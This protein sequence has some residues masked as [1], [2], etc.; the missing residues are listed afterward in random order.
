MENVHG[1]QGGNGGEAGVPAHPGWSTVL[2]SHDRR[3]AAHGALVLAARELDWDLVPVGDG[4]WFVLVPDGQLPA[5]RAELAD[6]LAE[7]RRR[8]LP[9]PQPLP[10]AALGALVYGLV[11]VAFGLLVETGQLGPDAELL[12]RVEASA[13]REGEWWRAV[14]ALTLHGGP[15]HLVA[16][17]IFGA[18]FGWLV[19]EVA[20]AGLA[21]A[22]ILV[23]GALGNLANV[24]LRVG[25]H[26][27]IG[28]S[29]AIFGALGLLGGFEGLR[30]R[31]FGMS[32]RRRWAPLIG[33][34]A[35]FALFGT[36]GDGEVLPGQAKTDVAAHLFGFLAGIALS[37]ALV[38]VARRW[39][40]DV[41]GGGGGRG[42]DGRWRRLQ[43]GAAAFALGVLGVAW[44]VAL[45]TR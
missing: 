15:T 40:A 24:Y 9:L 20:G 4:R 41:G 1:G 12:G 10:G 38:F 39:A 28:A 5:A 6:Y 21:W 23:S 2:E 11:L 27:S 36:G 7:N 25:E 19:A 42:G 34:L 30:R 17:L 35:L 16:N 37:P 43:W 18:L 44:A 33:A 45:G 26:L 8:V 14:T 31:T 22:A 29:T 3:A 13:I 32:R